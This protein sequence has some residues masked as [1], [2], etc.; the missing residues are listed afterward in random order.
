MLRAAMR[1]SIVILRL[2]T[3]AFLFGIPSVHVTINGCTFSSLAHFHCFLSCI[4]EWHISSSCVLTILTTFMQVL[5][6][7]LQRFDTLCSLARLC[8]MRVEK[9]LYHG[10]CIY[11]L[12]HQFVRC[13]L[14]LPSP[15]LN[16]LCITILR[17]HRSVSAK[18]RKTV[19]TAIKTLSP[20]TYTPLLAAEK[21]ALS[22][23][24]VLS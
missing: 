23:L 24:K 13:R 1:T 9:I 7:F 8:N 22:F 10:T 16:S 5:V 6:G 14:M 21:R 20:N 3:S 15:C 19:A 17:L 2:R 4:N 12:C 18:K 11:T